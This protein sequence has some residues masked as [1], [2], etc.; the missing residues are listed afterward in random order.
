MNRQL[1]NSVRKLAHV[2]GTD[3]RL[4]HNSAAHSLLGLAH[5]GRTVIDVGVNYGQFA[6]RISPFSSK[7]TLINPSSR[8]QGEVRKGVSCCFKPCCLMV[9]LRRRDFGGMAV[10]EFPELAE[11]PPPRA[12]AKDHFLVVLRKP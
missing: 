6:K 11:H 7:G 9:W 12:T 1:K 5:V 4:L 10:G 8:L 3:I 2:F